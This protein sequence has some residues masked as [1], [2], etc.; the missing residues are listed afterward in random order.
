[1]LAEIKDTGGKYLVSSDGDVWSIRSGKFIKPCPAG[2]GYGCVTIP[3]NG[4]LKKKYVHALVAEAFIGP[5][6]RGL[7]INHKDGVR[8]NNHVENL[9]Y[10]THQQNVRHAFEHGLMRIGS[11]HGQAKLN[12]TL[13]SQIKLDLS[14]TSLAEVRKKY[15]LAHGTLNAIAKGWTWKAVAPATE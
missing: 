5:R 2:R 14:H 10:V 8:T 13:V 1:M 6:P 12:E 3:I 7:V 9:E 4:R 11:R 15:Q